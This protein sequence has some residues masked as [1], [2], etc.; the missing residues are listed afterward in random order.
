M[1]GEN[2][3]ETDIGIPGRSRD[4]VTNEDLRNDL[5]RLTEIVRQLTKAIGELKDANASGSQ[6]RREDDMKLASLYA[7]ISV[8]R[9]AM[10][11]VATFV[12]AACVWTFNNLTEAINTN[13]TQ[14]LRLTTLEQ[15]RSVQDSRLQGLERGQFADRVKEGGGR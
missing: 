13:R 4:N 6:A 2:F 15:A 11:L 12:G 3:G 1:N 5:T 9:W 8:L 10:T 7:G 14:E